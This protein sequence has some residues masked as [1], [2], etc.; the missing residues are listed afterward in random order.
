MRPYIIAS[1]VT[2]A[3]GVGVCI[4]HTP[5]YPKPGDK[6]PAHEIA[7]QQESQERYRTSH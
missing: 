4:K 6:P 1:V 7:R 5:E 2:I 3:I